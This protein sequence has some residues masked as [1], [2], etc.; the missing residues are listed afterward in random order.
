RPLYEAVA[1][2]ACEWNSKN[3]IGLVVGATYPQELQRIRKLCPTMPLLIPGV[4]AQGG[5]L[6]LAVKYGMD[7]A[8]EKAIINVSRQVLYA[9]RGDEFAHSARQ[10]ALKLRNAIN[11]IRM[12]K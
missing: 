2:K 7:T 11:S 9:S 4:G 6:E 1:L 12:G 3:N 10:E 8:G 5:D